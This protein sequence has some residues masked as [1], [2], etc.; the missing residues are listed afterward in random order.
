MTLSISCHSLLACRVSAERSDVNLMWECAWVYFNVDLCV[1]VCMPYV[2][3]C[4]FV[5][6]TAK[7]ALFI[8]PSSSVRTVTEG[9]SRGLR[10]VRKNLL[11]K[12]LL[13]PLQKTRTK[14]NYIKQ[15]LPSEKEK[16]LLLIFRK[17]HNTF[18]YLGCASLYSSTVYSEP[19][20]TRCMLLLVSIV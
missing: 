1:Y 11:Q 15:N 5:V 6:Y 14:S 17:I 18:Q 12:A 4:V 8:S 3:V 7:W 13:W 2:R 16:N 19:S 20:V 9:L 10:M